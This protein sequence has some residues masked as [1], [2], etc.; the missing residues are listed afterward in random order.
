MKTDKIRKA[1]NDLGFKKQVL[2]T[3]GE[4]EKIAFVAGVDVIDVMVYLRSKNR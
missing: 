3:L 1:V 4:L 2:F